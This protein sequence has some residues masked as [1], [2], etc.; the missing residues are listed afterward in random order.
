MNSIL[1]RWLIISQ[2]IRLMLQRLI[3][4]DWM[5]EVVQATLVFQRWP[6][7]Q[8]A[9]INL[10]QTIID[11]LQAANINIIDQYRNNMVI[12]GLFLIGCY[13]SNINI[14]F[15]NIYISGSI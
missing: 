11:S 14:L 1:F 8:S 10:F 6:R 5:Y 2:S 15:I 4:Y 3:C 12:R 13:N 7:L 9:L